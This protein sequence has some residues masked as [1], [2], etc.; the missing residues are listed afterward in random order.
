MTLH[1]IIGAGAVGTG[2]AR[3]LADAGHDVIIVTR[4]GSGPDHERITKVRGDATDAD[5]LTRIAAGSRTIFNCAN[6]S[7][8]HRW[9]ELWPPMASA[10]L[11][12]AER[13]GARLVTM[14]NLYGYAAD[15]SPMAA[16]DPLDP[17]TAN[18]AIRVAMW[19]QAL[20]AHEAG[21]VQV[22]EIRASDYVGPDLGDTSHLGDRFVPPI[23]A[24]KTARV[25]GAPDIAHSWSY[26]GDVCRTM[27]V[28][29]TDDRAF[30]RAWHVPTLPP[31][32]ARSMGDAIARAAGV[33]TP[34]V[35]QIPRFAVR[36][37]GL[38]VPL[39]R[40]LLHMSYQ[41]DEPFVIDAIDTIDTFGIE[42]TPLDEQLRALL[43][44]YD[45]IVPA[46]ASA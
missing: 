7:A 13:T 41:F 36:A 25:L 20:A 31:A 43:A 37:M 45:V 35:K 22:T 28:V 16:T 17:P 19:H 38:V 46:P 32:S 26:I 1:T 6:P 44:S 12:A 23:L 9:A 5:L 34:T 8:Y 21:R 40:T 27:A 24:G 10:I 42:P 4:S 3:L 15:S 29:G 14:G 2:T 11:E 33:D 18:G 39:F 30:G